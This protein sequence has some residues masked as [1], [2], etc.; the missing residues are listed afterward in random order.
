MASGLAVMPANRT[1]KG[2]RVVFQVGLAVMA[3]VM[4]KGLRHKG[5][6]PIYGLCITA[7]GKN[8]MVRVVHAFGLLLSLVSS[9]HR[10]ATTTPATSSLFALLA[11]FALPANNH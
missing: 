10:R 5:L 1:T 6:G 11:A 2:F 7:A 3:A 4:A 9:L 8:T